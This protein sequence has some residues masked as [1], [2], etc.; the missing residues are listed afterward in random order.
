MR[1]HWGRRLVGGAIGLIGD[2]LSEGTSQAFYARLPGHPQQAADSLAQVGK[3]RGLYRFRGETDANSLTRIQEAW[4]DYE[5]G[6]TKQQMLKVV[7]Q[8]GVAGWPV[9][10]NTG[11]ITL[12]ESVNPFA[13]NFTISIPFGNISPA[14]S[15]NFYGAGRLYGDI[16]FYYGLGQ[17]LDVPML[18]YIVRKWKPS[19]SVGFI[20][21]YY[22]LTNF[23]TL[24]A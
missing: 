16:G 23:V 21:V 4:D 19:R 15:P 13:F 6:G 12:D 10:W 11:T 1:A 18:L 14:W 22:D 2:A 7:N 24:T 3:D 8:W 5:Q 9:T 20:K 17:N